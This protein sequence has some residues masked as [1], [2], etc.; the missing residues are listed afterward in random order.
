MII[1]SF[2]AFLVSSKRKNI[3]FPLKIIRYYLG[4]FVVL[5]ILSIFCVLILRDLS[6]EYVAINI[7]LV[8]EFVAFYIFIYKIV[9]SKKSKNAIKSLLAFFILA[10]LIYWIFSPRHLF[11]IPYPVYVFDSFLLIIPCL[12]Y[13]YELF[14]NS[15]N[16]DLKNHFP[17]WV[18]S[19]IL[20]YNC[21]SI[22]IFMLI[23]YIQFKYPMYY[24]V[25]FSINY[26]LYTILFLLFIRAFS[27][28]I[29]FIR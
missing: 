16:L 9:N 25:V 2:I 5:N 13:F 11:I 17:F 21:C 14:T 7:F 3:P 19:G 28:R 12:L 27:C 10:I 20:F 29:N 18:V 15:V 23:V 1:M 26:I 8:I 22:P 6:F 24:N 4:S